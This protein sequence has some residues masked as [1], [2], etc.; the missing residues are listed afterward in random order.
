MFWPFENPVALEGSDEDKLAKFREVR[1]K[2]AA[3]LESWLQ[4]TE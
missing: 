2:I 3:R 1:D 4:E